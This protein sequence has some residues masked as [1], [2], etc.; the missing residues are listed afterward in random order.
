MTLTPLRQSRVHFFCV[1]VGV[2]LC[3]GVC[4]CL[5]RGWGEVGAS[6]GVRKPTGEQL[7]HRHSYLPVSGP[8][9]EV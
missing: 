8:T 3:V 5:W 6:L 2:R 9:W 7:S 4:M 1:C